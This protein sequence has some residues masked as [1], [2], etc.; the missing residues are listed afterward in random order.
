MNTGSRLAVALCLA[1]LL[2]GCAVDR[3]YGTA[4]DIEVTDLQTLPE[5]R[6]DFI[7][8]IGP[9]QVLE[10]EV[11]GAELLSG[12]FLTDE[13]GRLQFPLVGMV[14]VDGKSP[15]EVARLLAESLRGT[16]VV[17]PQVRV[18]P[19]NFPVP[20]ISVGGEVERPGSYPAAGA[21]T[22]LRII[23]AAGGLDDFAKLDDILVL[24][25][26]NGQNYVGLYNMQAIQRG[27]YED[28]VL[29]PNDIVMVGDSPARR[30]FQTILQLV[31]IAT[32]ASVIIDRTTR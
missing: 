32:A 22:L 29:Y 8:R 16:Y 5:P 13:L 24:R 31:P 27:N 15:N 9:Q 7:Y 10:V 28:P 14:D 25:E 26:V 18:V 20:T 4:P 17:D 12:K 3:S 11:I 1:I 6:G 30:R 2:P 21:Q 19:D 23:N